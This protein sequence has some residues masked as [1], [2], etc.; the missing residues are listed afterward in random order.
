[1]IQTGKYTNLLLKLGIALKLLIASL[2]SLKWI[3]AIST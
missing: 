2:N 1:M 3:G